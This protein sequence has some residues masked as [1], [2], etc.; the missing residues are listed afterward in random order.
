[1][2][3]DFYL[4]NISPQIPYCPL[5][6]GIIPLVINIDNARWC[7]TRCVKPPLW[8]ETYT[9]SVCGKPMPHKAGAFLAILYM[10]HDVL[11]A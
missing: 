9:L 6:Y 4:A 8:G 1:M 2:S 3:M 11:L 10:C 5:A 7:T